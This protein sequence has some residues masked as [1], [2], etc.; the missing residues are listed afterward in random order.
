MAKCE[1]CKYAVEEKFGQLVSC[2]LGVLTCSGNRRFG[3]NPIRSMLVS[4][5]LQDFPEDGFEMKVYNAY[6]GIIRGD[7]YNELDSD[8]KNLTGLFSLSNE[9][10][11]DRMNVLALTF[12]TR[13]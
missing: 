4:Y 2:K 13:L 10:N 7:R 1:C 3:W 5:K 9:L 12:D 11:V 6:V 8:I